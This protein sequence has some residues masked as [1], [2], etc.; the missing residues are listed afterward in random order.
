MQPV[1]KACGKTDEIREAFYSGLPRF[2]REAGVSILCELATMRARTCRYVVRLLFAIFMAC[3]ARPVHAQNADDLTGNSFD[4][5]REASGKVVVLVFLRTDCPISN[6]YTPTIQDLSA[7]YSGQAA[8]W[9][10]YPDRKAAPAGIRHYLQDYALRVRPRDVVVNN[11][12]G[13]VLLAAGR[14]DEATIHLSAAVTDRPDYFDAHYNLGNAL[15]SKGEF[16]A[17]AVQF[18][19]ATRLQPDDADAEANLGSALAQMG[20]I[21]EAKSHYRRA[22]ML[23]PDHTLAR[24][25]LKE[26]EH[27]QVS[28]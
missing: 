12:L 17:A 20:Q 28:R 8:F 19:S 16:G 24:E 15:A 10:V 21:S 11:A 26:L 27:L 3:L 2:L 18:R 6:R 22:L 14:A 9:L 7:R 25:N 4:P 23:N 13:G 5:F 1:G